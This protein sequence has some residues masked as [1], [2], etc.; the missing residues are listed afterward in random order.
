MRDSLIIWL[1]DTKITGIDVMTN[2][3]VACENKTYVSLRVKG[4]VSRLLTWDMIKPYVKVG[5]GHESMVRLNKAG[6]IHYRKT[7][8]KLARG[9]G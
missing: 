5:V 9:E 2:D 7:I 3:R 1:H 6:N 8:A 4:G